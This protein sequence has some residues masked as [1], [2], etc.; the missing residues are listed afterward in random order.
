MGLGQF[1]DRLYRTVT[2]RSNRVAGGTWIS[3]LPPMPAADTAATAVEGQV[4][5]AGAATAYGNQTVIATTAQ[6]GAADLW[7]EGVEI[8]LATGTAG[9]FMVCLTMATGVTGTAAPATATMEAEVACYL[10]LA[11]GLGPQGQFLKIKP[12]IYVAGGS[13][14][15]GAVASPLG[16]KKCSVKLLMS[17]RK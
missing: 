2:P 13:Q 14:I 12:P 3:H 1:V 11:A 5:L 8:F 15:A 16:A 7:I 10:G 6:V 17:N 4:L 9:T